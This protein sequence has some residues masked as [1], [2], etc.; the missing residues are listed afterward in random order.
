MQIFISKRNDKKDFE[1][2][3]KILQS[4]YY[5]IIGTEDKYVESEKKLNCCKSFNN[6]NI[7]IK[8]IEG[9][10]HYLKCW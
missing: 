4:Q 8:K 5:Y 10:T 2:S 7:T 1:A 6:S 9:L 3:K